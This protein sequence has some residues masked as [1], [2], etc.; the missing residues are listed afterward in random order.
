M[1]QNCSEATIA[2]LSGLR[3][4]TEKKSLPT[5]VFVFMPSFHQAAPNMAWPRPYPF[6][7]IV[8]DII[9]RVIKKHYDDNTNQLFIYNATKVGHPYME[10]QGI[11]LSTHPHN[12]QKRQQY[13]NM[14]ESR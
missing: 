13:L 5:A 8:R 10:Y 6:V 7:H 9:E 3:T 14:L 12:L 11:V 4:A 2:T 1:S